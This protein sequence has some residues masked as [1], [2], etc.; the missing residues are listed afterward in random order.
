MKKIMTLKNF[1][2]LLLV[3]CSV[4][5]ISCKKVP[6]RIGNTIQPESSYIRVSFTGTQDIYAETQRVDSLSTKSA[7][8][9]LLGDMYDPVFGNSNLGF[10]TQLS[11][12]TNGHE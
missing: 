8:Y 3:I 11:L 7:N 1:M 5:I 6:E 10:Y 2:F 4:S 12:T 9:M